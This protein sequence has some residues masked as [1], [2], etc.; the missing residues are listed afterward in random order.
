MKKLLL[1]IALI[2]GTST[3]EAATKKTNHLTCMQK[4]CNALQK[5][6]TCKKCAEHYNEIKEEITEIKTCKSCRKGT[7]SGKQA[8]SNYQHSRSAKRS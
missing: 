4:D 7:R 6:N 2:A 5:K 3:I 8:Q 1:I